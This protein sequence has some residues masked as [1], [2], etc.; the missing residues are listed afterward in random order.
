MYGDRATV[1]WDEIPEQSLGETVRALLDAGYEPFLALDTPTEPP[2]FEERF[3]SQGP[4]AEPVARV[5]VV[6]IYKFMSA[7]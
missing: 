7:Y 4:Q 1:R 2:L 6:N 5:R 3:K